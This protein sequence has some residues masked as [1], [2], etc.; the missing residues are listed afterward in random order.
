M[1]HFRA[2][3][4]KTKD[5]RQGA[6]N[7]FISFVQPHKAVL[8]DTFS[9]WLKLVLAVAG[10]DT[11]QFG[12][13]STCAARTSAAARKGVALATIMKAAGWSSKKTLC[14]FYNK[15]PAQNFGQAIMDSFV[16]KS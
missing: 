3:L 12:S 5:I 4:D 2:Y 15:A 9:W 16:K 7:L 13:H 14:K 1:K 10:I 11:E 8:H 6:A